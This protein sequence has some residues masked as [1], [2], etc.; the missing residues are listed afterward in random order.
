VSLQTDGPDSFGTPPSCHKTL[1]GDLGL[2]HRARRDFAY[3]DF[4]TCENEG[5]C[6]W[7]S[8]VPKRRNPF[9]LKPIQDFAYRDFTTGEYEGTCPWVSR[10]PKRRNPFTL[11]P[12]RDFAYRDFA[13]GEYEGTCP[14]VSRVPKRRNPFTLKPIRDFAY[15][16]FATGE[17]EGT[18]PW[19]SRVP[20]RRKPIHA[21]TDS[22]FRIPGF[23]DWR[24]RR[25]LPLG[26]PGAE[27]SKRRKP[28]GTTLSCTRFPDLD[29][30]ILQRVLG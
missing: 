23:R 3:R 30:K 24:R 16:D 11:K 22:G 25:V 20:K 27:M 29:H 1:S 26:F 17:Y 8:R 15:Q 21:K 12:I 10:V 19:V 2:I 7:V 9:T 28:E 14:W 5:S 4:A 13:T 18:C 6:P